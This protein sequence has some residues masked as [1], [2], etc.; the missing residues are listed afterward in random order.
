MCFKSETTFTVNSADTGG[1][2]SSNWCATNVND[3]S[4][5]VSYMSIA[6]WVLVVGFVTVGQSYPCSCISIRSA[7]TCVSLP[8]EIW[9]NV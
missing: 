4:E 2:A 1:R 7:G 3:I 8:V 9:S 6:F 5:S